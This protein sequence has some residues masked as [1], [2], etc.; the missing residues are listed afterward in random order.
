MLCILRCSPALK[1]ALHWIQAGSGQDLDW[2]ILVGPF[3]LRIFR[4]SMN[5]YVSGPF[6]P[7]LAYS[8]ISFCCDFYPSFPANIYSIGSKLAF[9]P[10]VMHEN[11]LLTEYSEYLAKISRVQYL[12]QICKNAYWILPSSTCFF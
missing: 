12:L 9:L 2:N 3:Q 11:E 10:F 8:T 1:W 7:I 4:D 5:Q 6:F